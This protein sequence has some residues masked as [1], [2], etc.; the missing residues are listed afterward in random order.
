MKTNLQTPIT[1]LVLISY[2]YA[3]KCHNSTNHLY[4]GKPYDEAHLQLVVD[5]AIRFI[6]EYPEL[7]PIE[8]IPIVIS[9][10]WCHD[11]I[12]DTRQ[13]PILIAQPLGRWRHGVISHSEEVVLRCFF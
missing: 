12:E 10:C 8:M 11:T 13:T 5:T 7:I 6:Q 4:D 2:E 1:D 9:A 3:K